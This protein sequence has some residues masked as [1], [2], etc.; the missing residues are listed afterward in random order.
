MPFNS[1]T[2]N[3]VIESSDVNDNFDN[4]VHISDTQ[5]ILNKIPVLPVVSDNSGAF[6][7]DSSNWFVRT[8][9][10]S[11]GTLSLSNEDTNQVFI[12]ELAQDGTGSRTVSWWSGI[13][14]AGGTAPTLTTTASKRDVFG[15]RVTGA[16]TYLGF[17]VG[18]NI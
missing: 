17:V 11:N 9:D 1:F 6:D 4:A 12:V 14:W 13:S 16:G 10:G 3:T 15:F 8:L 7:L 18:I 2:P 5:K